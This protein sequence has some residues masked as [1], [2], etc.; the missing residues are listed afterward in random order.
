[1]FDDDRMTESPELRELRDS[2]D[3]L[4]MPGRPPLEAIAARSRARR[5]NRHTGVAG[6]FIAGAAA[7][8]VLTIALAGGGTS[9][10]DTRTALTP[11]GNHTPGAIRTG[12]YTLI[13]DTSGNVKLTISPGKLFHPA[14]LQSDLARFGIPAKVTDGRLCQSHPEPAGLSRIVTIDYHDRPTTIAFNPRTIPAGM[15]LSIGRFF[16]KR[17]VQLVDTV[18]IRTGSYSCTTDVPTD[19]PAGKP[20]QAIGFIAIP[21]GQATSHG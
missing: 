14:A 17:H 7:G 11:R 8:A 9:R 21:A 6:L 2:L 19:R 3:G 20:G 18:L 1:M 10:N 5:R 12:A 15:E 4:S 13:S 16:L